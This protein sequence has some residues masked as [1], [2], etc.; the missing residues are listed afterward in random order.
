MEEPGEVEKFRVL[1]A[2]D[3]KGQGWKD[4]YSQIVRA[5]VDYAKEFG[6]HPSH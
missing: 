1:G 2:Y 6:F 5:F 3:I 4:R